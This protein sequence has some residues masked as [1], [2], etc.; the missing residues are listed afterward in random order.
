MSYEKDSKIPSLIFF[1][2]ELLVILDL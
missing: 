2:S 1:L